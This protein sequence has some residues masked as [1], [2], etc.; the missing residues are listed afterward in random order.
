MAV[1]PGRVD[2]SLGR[3]AACDGCSVC[4]SLSGT[5]GEMLLTD[6]LDPLGA[7]V[8]DEVEIEIPERLRIQAALAIYV[9]PLLALFGG[10][11]AGFLLASRGDGNPDTAGALAGIGCATL[12]L[13]AVFFRERE[14]ARKEGFA[15]FVRAIIAHVRTSTGARHDGDAA[16]RRYA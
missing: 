16:D 8:G 13:A 15:P 2:V 9:A 3:S 6:V 12:T 5:G 4:S 11:L 1:R 10:Y 14:L 7:S